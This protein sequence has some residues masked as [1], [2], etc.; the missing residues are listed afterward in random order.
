[1]APHNADLSPNR[2]VRCV[3]RRPAPAWGVFDAAVSRAIGI[4]LW[5]DRRKQGKAEDAGLV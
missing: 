5:T 2:H 4:L 1:M 3:S